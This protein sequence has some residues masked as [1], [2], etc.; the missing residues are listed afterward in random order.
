MIAQLVGFGFPEGDAREAV[1][2]Y[3]DPVRLDERVLFCNDRAEA[4]RVDETERAQ[5]EARLEA[6]R[7]VEGHLNRKQDCDHRGKDR[8]LCELIVMLGVKRGG[9]KFLGR[10]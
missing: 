8:H 5:H 6:H 9:E 4:R 1:E 7:R 2:L 3:S 10:M